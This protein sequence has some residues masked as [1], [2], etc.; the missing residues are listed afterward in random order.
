MIR[1]VPSR[2]GVLLIILINPAAWISW[3]FWTCFMTATAT[4]V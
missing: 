2:E 1:P 3:L 4:W